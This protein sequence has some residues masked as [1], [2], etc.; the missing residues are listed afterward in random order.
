MNIRH[1]LAP[2]WHRSWQTVL[3]WTIRLTC[4]WCWDRLPSRAANSV[5][6]RRI[7]LMW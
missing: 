7:P 4:A 1:Q 5:A 6:P 2:G 3:V